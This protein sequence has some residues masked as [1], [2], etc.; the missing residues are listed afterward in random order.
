M[1]L[2][3]RN[4]IFVFGVI[5]TCIGLFVYAV[6]GYALLFGRYSGAVFSVSSVHSWFG[7]RWDVSPF[8]SYASLAAAGVLGLV[9]T[10]GVAVSARLFRRVSSA[11]IYFMTLFLISLSF[12]LVRIGQP[13]LE[14]NDMP[15]A[16]SALL[17]RIV[18]FGRLAGALSLFAAGVYSA[19]ADYPRIGSVTL[20]IASLS[21]L[22]VYLIP[23][24]TQQMNAT[25]M[26]VTGGREA[27]DLL[28][29]FLSVGAI[30]NYGIGWWRGHRERGGAIA[31]TAIG[32]AIGKE[33][34]LHVPSPVSLGSGLILLGIATASFVLVNRSY[35]L[36]Y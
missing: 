6:A 7:L 5:V 23:V 20:L 25:F 18:L 34:V 24:D 30:A 36:W 35:Y 19:G 1:T 8:S 12:E 33:L 22:I 13:L 21:F 16:L 26:N 17:T 4:T 31:L 29:A 11:E 2:A 15:A 28:L 9:S 32:L 3:A 27:V 10:T 14:I